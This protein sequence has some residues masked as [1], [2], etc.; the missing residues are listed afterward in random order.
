[1][2]EIVFAAFD[3]GGD[4]SGDSAVLWS[5][6]VLERSL[7]VPDNL[8]TSVDGVRLVSL[9]KYVCNLQVKCSVQV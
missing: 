4:E 6:L 1:M 8:E 5:H 3:P 2:C 9:V 7:V